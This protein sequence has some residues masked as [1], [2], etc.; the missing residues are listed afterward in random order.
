[1][2]DIFYKSKMLKD[3]ERMKSRGYDLQPLKDAIQL[4][5][6]ELPLP[7][8]MKDHAL[9]GKWRGFRDCHVANDWILI[10]RSDGKKLEL[11]L[12]RTGTHS[13]LDF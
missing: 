5:A 11:T 12:A 2:L 10:Y 6:N 7:P 9:H 8:S 1:M 3:M 13:D 4:L